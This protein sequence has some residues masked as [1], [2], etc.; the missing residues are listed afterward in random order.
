[1]IQQYRGR[2]I[3]LLAPVGTFSDFEALLESG[4]DAFYM[5]GKDFNMRM[6]RKEHNLTNE[7][8]A[9]A[10]QKAHEKGKKIYVTANNMMTPDEIEAIEPFLKHLALIQPDAVIIQDMGVVR[11]IHEL[12]LPIEIHLSVMA[13]V[14]NLA[15]IKEAKKMGV[16]RIVASRELALKD[17]ERFVSVYPEM[18]YEYFIHGDMCS[19]HGS[20]CLYSGMI[21]GKS[22]NRGRCMKPCRWAYEAEGKKDYYALAVKDISLYEHIPQ[23]LNSGVNS[24]KIEGR[25][26]SSEHLIH[27][28]NQYREAID[29]FIESPSSY[30][31]DKE[32]AQ[33]IQNNRVRNLSTGYAFGKPG[34]SNIDADGK[35]EPR[36]FSKA[37]EEP[38][39]S[40]DL[41][42]QLEVHAA[43]HGVEVSSQ[44]VRNT[45]H[46]KVMT[47][48]SAVAAMDGGADRIYLSDEVFRPRKPWTLEAVNEVITYKKDHA[49]QAEI[50][51]S[52]PKMVTKENEEIL[53]R[54][55]AMLR[56]TEI[57]GFQIG[58]MGELGRIKKEDPKR[59]VGDY[60]LNVMNGEALAFYQ[61]HGV[62]Q[63]TLSLE[64]SMDVLESMLEQHGE[65]VEVVVQGSM[66]AMYME[67][68][69]YEADEQVEPE[70]DCK[71]TQCNMPY[72]L[73]D[74]K[75]FKHPVFSDQYCRSHLMT[76]KDMH[77]MPLL[78]SLI[79]L[80]GR[81][82]RIEALR[83]D[84]DTV[85]EVTYLYRHTLDLLEK[86][87]HVEND[88]IRHASR[89]I[90]ALT[91]MKQSFFALSFMRD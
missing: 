59:F 23:L 80:G 42:K 40:S 1:M 76:T 32:D 73:E 53:N 77:L 88:E 27:M 15:M 70:N 2:K 43:K 41:I 63:V 67:H 74:E 71:Q 62:E 11:R 47:P 9:I 45:L 75:G 51:Y 3:E 46:V 10:V 16:T 20:Q 7:E 61:E 58:H 24:F 18:E 35:R 4:A 85:R 26:R 91:H 28:I 81:H 65:Q 6:H 12:G 14:H 54:Q 56:Q 33:D 89:R 50:I 22:S 19:V 86:G 64:S 39:I 31:T 82:F 13:N 38:V 57:D 84:P 55:V 48:E 49:L 25:M 83:Y 90:E 37:V 68:C 8:L 87:I 78:H 52:L 60:G 79:E 29:R 30:Q 34:H 44:G 69:L 17:I 66:T 21:F 72:I 36:V 5:G